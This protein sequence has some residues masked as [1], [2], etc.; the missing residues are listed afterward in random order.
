MRRSRER[1]RQSVRL[2]VSAG[3]RK[4]V[5]G[6]AR[7]RLGSNPADPHRND[8]PTVNAGPALLFRER[9]DC[10]DTLTFHTGPY[11]ARQSVIDRAIRSRPF[12]C[13][14][15]DSTQLGHSANHQAIP[16]RTFRS[17][18]CWLF[19][20]RFCRLTGLAGAPKAD[21]S[22]DLSSDEMGGFAMVRS[23]ARPPT[24]SGF[25]SKFLGILRG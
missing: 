13:R 9:P 5:R 1:Q 15:P 23:R 21:I 19:R 10:G 8:R 16:D 20:A 14:G 24:Y 6:A 2:S 7:S 22:T 25:R 11:A 4:R 18:S 3:Q 12:G 17:A